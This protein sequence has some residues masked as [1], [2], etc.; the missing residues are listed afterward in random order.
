VWLDDLQGGVLLVYRDPLGDSFKTFLTLKG[1]DSVS[2]RT[3]PDIAFSV[4]ELLG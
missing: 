4:D 2:V 1:A 3:F